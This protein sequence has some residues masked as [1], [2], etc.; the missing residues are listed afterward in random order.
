MIK[1]EEFENGAWIALENNVKPLAIY[2]VGLGGRTIALKKVQ[3]VYFVPLDENGFVS[4][5]HAEAIEKM[6]KAKTVMEVQAIANAAGI[7]WLG[8]TI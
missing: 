1:P 4:P 3:G 5:A 2:S 6:K 7:A 8:G